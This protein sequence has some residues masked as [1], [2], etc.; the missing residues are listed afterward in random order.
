[1]KKQK[2]KKADKLDISSIE[3]GLVGALFGF[4]RRVVTL[5]RQ[6]SLDGAKLKMLSERIEL[7]IQNVT[8]EIERS[9]DVNLAERFEL[10]YEEIRCLVEELSGKDG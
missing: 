1:M 5:L 8:A 9:Q 2:T 10:A 4:H 3:T 6:S 7:V